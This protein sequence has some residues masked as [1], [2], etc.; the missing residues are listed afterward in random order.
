M[1]ST[2]MIDSNGNTFSGEM[3]ARKMLIG[4]NDL[5]NI[6]YKAPKR[7]FSVEVAKKIT[8]PH[9]QDA[10]I[11]I[12]GTQGKGKSWTGL[13][14]AYSTAKQISKIIN[15]KQDKNTTWKDFFSMDNIVIMDDSMVKEVLSDVKQ[16]N[17]YIFDDIGIAWNA[18]ESMSKGN[19]LLNDVF[20]VF[21]T[22][23]TAVILSIISPFL[24]DKVP[25]NLVN[26]QIEMDMNLFHYGWTFSKLFNV[27]GRARDSAPH[28]H[29][30]KTSQE[31]GSVGIVRVATP[32]P[33]KFLSDTY[34]V[35]RR[36]AAAKLRIE[37]MTRDEENE[38]KKKKVK[39]GSDY[40]NEWK[41]KKVEA[42]LVDKKFSQRAACKLMECDSEAYRGWR[43]GKK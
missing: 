6:V 4:A 23:N 28:Y 20:Q 3:V 9:N 12:V 36:E 31:S 38:K 34:D 22:E 10:R 13:T 17:I 14:L 8:S 42:L 43:D 33:P 15:R 16:Y 5:T 24:I 41:Y 32:K 7:P 25:R 21:R 30:Q 27:V 37:R 19:K 2:T 18:R 29:Y 26:Y 1:E 35:H 39:T 40:P 11:M